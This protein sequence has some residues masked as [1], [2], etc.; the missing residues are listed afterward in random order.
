MFVIPLVRHRERT[1][2]HV[3]DGGV[4]KAVRE[5]CFFKPLD[6][7]GRFLVELPGDPPAD[8][9]QFDAVDFD[10]G[11]TIR[12]HSDKAADAAGRLQHVAPLEPHVLKR[13]ID[14]AYD[15]RR[16]IKG[17]QGGFPR[18]GVFVLIQQGFQFRIFAVALVKAVRKAAPA[19]ILRQY[20][21]FFR[22][23][24][25]ILGFQPFQQ[26]D[27]PHV[28]VEPLPRRPHTDGIVRNMILVALPLRDLRVHHKGGRPHPW[29]GWRWG[30][31][32][33]LLRLLHSL[34]VCLR[35]F[36]RLR[37]PL[38]R[39]AVGEQGSLGLRKGVKA[40]GCGVGCVLLV[41]I[42][43]VDIVTRIGVLID[44]D[45]LPVRAVSRHRLERFSLS[46]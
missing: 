45:G 2:G 27:G 12:P 4:K 46:R 16:G 9:V 31:R 44:Q 38:R 21:L 15:N 17:R 34:G 23:S 19:N 37:G 36:G 39:R 41:I 11:H 24:Q 7:N 33:F 32:R 43:V 1:K 22:C 5:V 18:C 3:A 40:P 25:P 10:A 35:F 42:A 30:E 8:A 20:L 13:L 14:S 26:A 29:A 6:S 28:V